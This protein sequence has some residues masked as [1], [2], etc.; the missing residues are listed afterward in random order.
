M[1]D[2]LIS[3]IQ[4]EKDSIAE[5]RKSLKRDRAALEEEKTMMSSFVDRQKAMNEMIEL[6]VGGEVMATKRGTLL[7]AEGTLLEAMFS[8][9]WDCS[10]DR[11]PS[12]RIFLDFSPSVF[13]ILLS[14]LRV[15]RDEQSKKRRKLPLVPDVHEAEFESMIHFLGLQDFIFGRNL[16]LRT[17]VEEALSLKPVNCDSITVENGL[18][19]SDHNHYH[20][21]RAVVGAAPLMDVVGQDW[22]AWKVSILELEFWL[23]VGVIGNCQPGYSSWLDNTSY[24]WANACET[25]Q[26]GRKVTD[27]RK[28]W[29]GWQKGD[30]AVF[31]LDGKSGFLTMFLIRTMS[32][33]VL[34]V[35]V[36]A[37]RSLRLHLN[38]CN[39]ST[40]VKVQR[41]NDGDLLRA[42]ML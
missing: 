10:L 37:A 39:P 28:Q 34:N 25:Y 35:G 41:C 32:T 26:G 20:N 4:Q 36:E 2:S 21:H 33:Y 19:S 18:V 16:E 27:P 13:R 11:D 12:G 5:S 9:R 6:N 31:K 42:G 1:A 24:G 15:I 8:G 23:H 3:H 22:V 30:E 40:Q 29:P 38:L 17:P 7:I 14:H